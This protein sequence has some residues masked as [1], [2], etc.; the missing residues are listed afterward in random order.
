MPACAVEYQYG[1]GT[2]MAWAP[3]AT[4]FD[5]LTGWAF[6]AAVST[7]GM[8][9]AAVLLRSGHGRGRQ[10]RICRPIGIWCRAAR[11]GGCHD[12]PKDRPGD[13]PG[14]G[15]GCL[16]GRPGL[17][18]G[19][20]LRHDHGRPAALG[21][22]QCL[23]CFCGDVCSNVSCASGSDFGCCG[24]TESRRNPSPASCLPTVRSC[25]TTP[26]RSSIPRLRS[27]RRQRTTPPVAGSGPLR[28][29]C[30]GSS[31]CARSSFCPGLKRHDGP[32]TRRFD[33]PGR[34]SA[35][36][37]GASPVQG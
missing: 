15:S 3:G 27:T 14:H 25:M 7:C 18:P 10:R 29:R 33:K 26:K 30:A 13:R 5:I 21:P 11:V 24:R 22:W 34:P 32:D 28:T 16:V 36:L 12:R 37:P 20:R 6:I 9:S 35:S 23:A 19:T 2:K 4:A 8:T 1:M 17:H 31:F